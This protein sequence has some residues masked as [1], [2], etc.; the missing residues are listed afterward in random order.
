MIITPPTLLLPFSSSFFSPHYQ[1]RDSLLGIEEDIPD[2]DVGK[3]FQLKQMEKSGELDTRAEAYGKVTAKSGALQ[4][5]ARMR[6]NKPYYERNQAR[7]C[8]FYAKGECTRGKECPYRHELP[9]TGALAKQNM[10]DRYYGVNDPVANK[11]LGALKDKEGSS[12]LLSLTP[13]ADPTVKTLWVGGLVPDINENDLRDA[14]Y[15]YGE[16]ESAHVIRKSNGS[17]L[18]TGG[19][20]EGAVTHAAPFG[21]ITYTTRSAAE[22]AADALQGG[23]LFIKGQAV[24][25]KWAKPRKESDPRGR[26]YGSDGTGVQHPTGAGVGIFYAGNGPPGFGPGNGGGGMVYKS[27]DP[28][29][30]GSAPAN[31]GGV[32]LP[33]QIQPGWG[34]Y[35]NPPPFAYH[36]HHHHHH[37]VPLHPHMNVHPGPYE[38]QN[39]QLHHPC[40]QP[41]QV[42]GGMGPKPPAGNPPSKENTADKITNAADT[43]E[44]TTAA[45]TGGRQDE[46]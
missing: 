25:L 22:A 40:A 16:I 8:T 29:L 19:G 6:G 38:G 5:V 33:P 11:I 37:H 31:G 28:S 7:L 4:Q 39:P 10:K 9:K 45:A 43:E 13:P 32:P 12:S 1:V 2:S 20:G 17:T 18:P 27:M 24:S 26:N 3:E 36:H 41:Q 14:F 44:P 23:K 35:N 15:G 42:P 21:F 46:K 34:Q 30:M